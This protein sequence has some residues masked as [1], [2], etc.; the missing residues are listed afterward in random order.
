VNFD[1]SGSS[2]PDPGN[3]ITYSWDLNGDGTF[4]DATV[5]KPSYTYSTVGT[6]NAVLKVTDNNGASSTSAPITITVTGGA[7]S[8]FGTTTPGTSI[9]LASANFKE[10]SKFN[11]PQAG[12]VVKVTGYVSGLGATSGTQKLRAVIY[13]DSS[14]NPGTR[15]GVSNEVTINA[16]QAWGWVNFTF[17]SAVAIQAGTIWIGYFGGAK[18]DLTQLRYD[19]VANDLRYNTNTYTSGASNPFGAATVSNKHYSIYATYG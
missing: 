8:T 17:P 18:H 7:G 9:D 10:V 3:T 6:Y 5:A 13:A 12:N 19:P 14:G 15:L 4:G 16:N 1:G 2:D 11:A